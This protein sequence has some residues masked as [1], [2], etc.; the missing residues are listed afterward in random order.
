MLPVWFATS[1]FH[2]CVFYQWCQNCESHWFNVIYNNPWFQCNRGNCREAMYSMDCCMFSRGKFKRRCC[3]FQIQTQ[4]FTVECVIK[5]QFVVIYMRIVK[6][7]FYIYGFVYMYKILKIFR[8]IFN[9]FYF[10][11]FYYLIEYTDLRFY[12]F[13]FCIL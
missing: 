13:N 7:T 11:E 5:P 6:N 4:Y 12:A 8:E 9:N 3:R 10:R 1:R 2:Y